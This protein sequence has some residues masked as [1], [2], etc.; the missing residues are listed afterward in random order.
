[1]T[2]HCV[3][4]DLHLGLRETNPYICGALSRYFCYHV[5]FVFSSLATNVS[6][7]EILFMLCFGSNYFRLFK[8]DK[9]LILSVTPTLS[10]YELRR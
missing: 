2:N 6:Q 9:K 8:L 10:S 4:S 5:G 7:C 1:M 3:I